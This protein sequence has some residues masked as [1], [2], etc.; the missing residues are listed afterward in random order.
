ML[1]IAC[2]SLHRRPGI[3]GISD[4]VVKPGLINVDFADVRSVMQDAG[5]A[6][7]G[8]GTGSGKTRAR[9]AAVAAISSPLLD[10]PIEK[11]K[12][13]V[14][15]ITGNSGMSLQEVNEVR[16]SKR[17]ANHPPIPSPKYAC[18]R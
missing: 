16:A 9:D 17:E 13:V 12:G 15:T 8:I 4:I 14:F 6:L 7:M 2:R 18:P 3:T 11:A 1:L 5:P 10:F